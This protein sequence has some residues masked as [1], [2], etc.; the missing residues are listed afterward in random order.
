MNKLV[1]PSILVA[2]VLVAGFFAFTPINKASTVHTTI[3]ASLRATTVITD[4]SVATNQR[5]VILDNAGI[6]GTS[7]VEVTWRFADA[8]C[9]VEVFGGTISAGGDG[10]ASAVPNAPAGSRLLQ[11]DAAF[12]GNPP[13]AD[14]TA[15]NG[16]A[17]VGNGALCDL[18]HAVNDFV[19][20]TT[21]KGST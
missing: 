12:G 4:A 20:V 3:L 6:A 8:D 1:I 21:V 13:H 11:N 14:V 2:A 19:S 7:D 18:N 15:T 17:L 10:G 16:V 5:L 9:R